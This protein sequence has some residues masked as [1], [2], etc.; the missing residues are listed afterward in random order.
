MIC[1]FF[2]FW[3]YRSARLY[4]KVLPKSCLY[5]WSIVTCLTSSYDCFMY[6]QNDFWFQW[7]YKG[8]I[9]IT[10][11]RMTLDCNYVLFSI[12]RRQN[13]APLFFYNN[14]YIKKEMW[15]AVQQLS[16]RNQM[17]KNNNLPACLVFFISHIL[18]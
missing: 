11:L 16:T 6:I 18:L 15:V 9:F 12:V 17:A 7:L 13:N 1:F 4:H 5:C 3:S 10:Y 14:L 8:H 2:F